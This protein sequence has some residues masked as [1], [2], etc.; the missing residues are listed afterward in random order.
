MRR[1]PDP[2]MTRRVQKTLSLG[3]LVLYVIYYYWLLLLLELMC[4][5]NTA[6]ANDGRSRS[7]VGDLPKVLTEQATLCEIAD[8]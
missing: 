1:L 7:S 3:I 5:W 6:G 8:G 4:Y 2:S